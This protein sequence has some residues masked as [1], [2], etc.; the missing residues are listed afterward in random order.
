MT[1]TVS[2]TYTLA[3]LRYKQLRQLKASAVT[4]GI[5]ES[6]HERTAMRIPDV[7]D[8]QPST[9]QAPVHCSSFMHAQTWP[10]RTLWEHFGPNWRAFLQHD[11]SKRMD[12]QFAVMHTVVFHLP[13]AGDE[14]SPAARYPATA[15]QHTTTTSLKESSWLASVKTAT[16]YHHVCKKTMLPQWSV[17]PSRGLHT[18]MI[19]KL[20]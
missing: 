11:R 18:C 2:T 9:T 17:I 5:S 14:P 10:A 6:T 4:H 16:P 12:P 15:E 3:S 1:A 7:L 20:V 8:L 19:S 13:R